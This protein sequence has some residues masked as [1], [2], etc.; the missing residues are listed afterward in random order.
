MHAPNPGGAGAGPGIDLVTVIVADYDE[1]IRFYCTALGFVVAEDAAA[2]TTDGRPK[3]WVVVRPPAGGTGLLLAKADDAEQRRAV[4][5]QFAG[6][7]G[8]FLRV[9]DF[10]VA[11]R[12]LLDNAVPIVRP[13]RD[14]A[15]GRVAVFAD[16]CGNHWDLLGPAVPG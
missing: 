9:P 16:S 11:Y 4:G 7:V 8:L 5:A 3:R 6:R 14:E 1:A 10:D 13:P 12:R 2:S 15:Y